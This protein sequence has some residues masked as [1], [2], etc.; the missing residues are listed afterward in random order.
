VQGLLQRRRGRW[1]VLLELADEQD[2]ADSRARCSASS[3]RSAGKT[4]Q[5]ELLTLL[6]G[7]NDQRTASS[8]S[9][10]ARAASMRAT[11][12]RCCCACT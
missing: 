6:S 12:P 1:Q 8:A 2:D 9:R 5:V 10:P 11:S 7:E 3:N 4:D